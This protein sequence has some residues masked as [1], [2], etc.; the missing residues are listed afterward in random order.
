MTSVRYV[1]VIFLASAVIFTA[2]GARKD[3]T[4]LSDI[5]SNTFTEGQYETRD[6]Y[7]RRVREP[8]K[9]ISARLV[10]YLT[11]GGILQAISEETEIPRNELVAGGASQFQDQ[12]SGLGR[13]VHAAHVIRVGTIDRR[14]GGKDAALQKA[15]VNYIGHTQNVL[16]A[17]NV[18]HGVGGEIDRFQSNN[19]GLLGSIDFT[20]A[21]EPDNRKVVEQLVGYFREIIAAYVK[22]GSE[23]DAKDKNILDEDK[24]I[25][26]CVSPL[27]LFEEGRA[28]Y[29]LVKSG[30]FV[31]HYGR[32]SKKNCST[33]QC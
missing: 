16:R 29:D 12:S 26:C 31:S 19:L 25:L 10:R 8:N 32:T 6:E 30:E 27:M 4:V 9:H 13:T 24:V 22:D 18:W 7:Q 3:S 17:A 11:F 5:C 1:L 33:F 23:Y 15:L 21:F 28:G 20:G 2:T 14:L